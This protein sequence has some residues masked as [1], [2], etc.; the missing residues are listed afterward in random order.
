MV[1]T[2]DHNLKDVTGLKDYSHTRDMIMTD[3]TDMRKA[4][5]PT[6]VDEFL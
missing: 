2:R 6:N 4:L 1:V 3:L 5:N